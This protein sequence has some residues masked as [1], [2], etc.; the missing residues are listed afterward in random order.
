MARLARGVERYAAE[1]GGRLPDSIKQI[2]LYTPS[3]E[4]IVVSPRTG[5]SPG[6]IYEKPANHISEVE[7]GMGVGGTII[8]YEAVDGQKNLKGPCIYLDGHCGLGADRKE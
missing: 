3:F 4:A 7:K 6:Y 2:A 5:E 1:N 8:F